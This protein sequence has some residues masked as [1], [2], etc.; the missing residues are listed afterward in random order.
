M[1]GLD[2]FLAISIIIYFVTDNRI[3]VFI[4]NARLMLYDYTDDDF[5][6]SVLSHRVYNNGA[7]SSSSPASESRS[8]C[9]YSARELQLILQEVRYIT[10]HMRKQQD[11]QEVINDWKYAAMVV[12][13]FCLIVFTFFTLVATVAVMYSAPHIIVEWLRHCVHFLDVHMAV[14]ILLNIYFREYELL[15]WNIILKVFFL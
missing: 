13:R 15:F 14:M 1:H 7:A 6:A 8:V 11:D 4:S 3:I 12:D 10:D 9:N 2:V 5:R